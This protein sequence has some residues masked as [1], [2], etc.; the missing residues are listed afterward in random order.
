MQER[1]LVDYWSYVLI[2]SALLHPIV[3]WRMRSKEIMVFLATSVVISTICGVI[4]LVD[5]V[6]TTQ[7][8][9]KPGWAAPL[10]VASTVVAFP[11]ACTTGL[12]FHLARVCAARLA[13]GKANR[14]SR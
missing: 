3:Y 5:L 2:L 4:N 9:V 8:Q 1:G 7:G 12:L 13:A 6:V 11:A 10:V 14:S